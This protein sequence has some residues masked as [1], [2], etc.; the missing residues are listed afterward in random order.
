MSAGSA[1]VKTTDTRPNGVSSGVKK[2]FISAPAGV[3][4][5][6]LREALQRRG[7]Q[8]FLAD[9]VNLPGRSISEV[10]QHSMAQADFVIGVL[11]AQGDNNNVLLELGFALGL[12]KRVLVFSPTDELLPGITLTGMATIRATLQDKDGSTKFLR[13]PRRK[14]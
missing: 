7:I 1:K 3:D 12:H 13:H 6:I 8:S 10:L 11:G 9:E 4:T 14:R 2:A 5:S